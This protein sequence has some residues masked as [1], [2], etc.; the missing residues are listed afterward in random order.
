VRRV[1]AFG[2]GRTAL[3][4]AYRAAGFEVHTA[5]KVGEAVETAFRELAAGETL[6]FSPAA[7]SF[8][9]YLNFQERALDFRRA[10][11]GLGETRF[12]TRMKISTARLQRPISTFPP[13]PAIGLQSSELLR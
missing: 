8:D 7:A 4:E 13:G 3:A 6:L 9:Q 12:Q 2:A 1:I 10:V 5:D 11:T